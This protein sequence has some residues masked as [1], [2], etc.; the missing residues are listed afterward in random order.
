MS[1]DAVFDKYLLHQRSIL[2]E[3]AGQKI[4][5]QQAA[6]GLFELCNRERRQA[7]EGGIF[8]LLY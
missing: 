5:A 1:P 6:S 4:Q 2:F 7:D 8:E 3:C